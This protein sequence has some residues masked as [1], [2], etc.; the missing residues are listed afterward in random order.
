M[1]KTDSV[2]YFFTA[3]FTKGLMKTDPV[4][5]LK[6]MFRANYKV[7]TSTA[8]FVVDFEYVLVG[9]FLERTN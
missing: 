5:G 8:F 7:T 3:T 6:N 4:T 9:K 2:T 1:L